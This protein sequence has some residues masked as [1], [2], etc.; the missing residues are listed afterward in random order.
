MLPSITVPEANILTVIQLTTQLLA[1]FNSWVPGFFDTGIAIQNTTGYNTSFTLPSGALSAQTGPIMAYLY[2]ADGS[3]AK[4][5]T[6]T[7]IAA[8][9]TP[10]DQS[11]VDASGNVLPHATYIILLSNLPSRLASQRASPDRFTSL[12]IS[13]MH[14]GSTTSRIKISRF[15]L[16][17]TRCL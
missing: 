7:A 12:Q 13:P 17:D 3:A 14:M 11:G 16:R 1:Q 5:I 6:S 9:A 2:P 8:S 15:P 4:T 10:T